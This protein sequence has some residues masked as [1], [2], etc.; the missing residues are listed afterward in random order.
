MLKVHP[1][2]G[3]L[4]KETVGV[5]L[6]LVCEIANW[7]ANVPME[8]PN[9]GMLHDNEGV[10]ERAVCTILALLT[11]CMGLPN[12]KPKIWSRGFVLSDEQSKLMKKKLKALRNWKRE[13]YPV[14]GYLYENSLSYTGK[15][16][17]TS[18]PHGYVVERRTKFKW[19][20]TKRYAAAKKIEKKF[21]RVGDGI[22][23]LA[24]Q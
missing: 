4:T 24:T 17:S 12:F 23:Q 5:L 11:E 14:L 3:I 1:E 16:V 20:L 7:K 22:S 15:W 10:K 18:E 19:Y 9:L 8:K 6:E 21:V 2:K 13:D